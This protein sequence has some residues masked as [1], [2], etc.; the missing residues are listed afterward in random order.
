M[1][2][3]K[4]KWSGLRSPLLRQKIHSTHLFDG[5]PLH[6]VPM[7]GFHER[8]GLLV[9]QYGS[10]DLEF[11]TNGGEVVRT[12]PGIAHFLEHEL[13][14]KEG[15]DAL[16]EFGR[17]GA[18]AN[19]YTDYAQTVY[20]FKG[21]GEFEPCLNL[22][23]EMTLQPY[24]SEEYVRRERAIIEQELRMYDD[25]PDYASYRNLMQMLYVK[26][27][28]RLD[29][30]GRVED[31]AQITHPLLETCYRAF[32]H[33]HRM[34]LL[35]A[36]DLNPLHVAETCNRIM[37]TLKRPAASPAVRI[38]REEPPSSQEKE[39]AVKMV[40]SRPRI[41]IGF[42]DTHLSP[43]PIRD[44]ILTSMALDLT[45]GRTS[46]FY[47]RWYARG[48]IDDSFGVQAKRE[49]DFGFALVGGETD[50]PD[51][52]RDA[53]LA[54]VVKPR[55]HRFKRRDLSRIQR[56]ALGRTIAAFDSPDD[57]ASLV[58]TSLAQGENPFDLIRLAQRVQPSE[59]ERRSRDL[60]RADN[61][62]VSTV[63]P[64]EKGMP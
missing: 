10:I 64:S 8:I 16:M 44:R 42:K 7:T 9:V 19:A 33:P 6:V 52:L 62:A 54:E 35:T 39:R 46:D 38:P 58:S 60:F 28:A 13:F 32:Y 53:I 22:L 51:R 55:K 11:Q 50:D 41:L 14:K 25:I 26:H 30:G 36:G 49:A 2:P 47:Q 17:Y 37:R 27:P 59:L 4:D 43:R 63:H 21:S 40:S 34:L 12:P 31:L 29:I 61:W 3:V 15:K 56:R 20:Y 18:S 48:L 1:K 24:F 23:L 5:L 45:F 57:A